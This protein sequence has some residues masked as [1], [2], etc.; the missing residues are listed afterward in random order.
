ME[1]RNKP[2]V[3]IIV[4]VYN[5]EKYLEKCINSILGQSYNNI[6]IILIDDGSTDESGFICDEYRRKHSNIKVKHKSNAGLGYARNTGLELIEGKYVTFIDSDDWVSSDLI[7]H[8]YE[9]TENNQVDFCKSGFQRVKHNGEIVSVTQY[10]EEIYEGERAAKELLPRLVGSSP[11]KHDSLEMCVCG[12]LYN[13]DIIKTNGIRF[14]SER[15]LIS[16][17]LVF[18]ID[19]LQHANG[20]CSIDAV[21]YFYC[22][23]NVS[24]SQGYRSDR[25]EASAYFYTEMRKKLEELGYDRD[26]ILRLDRMFFLYVQ[27]S[28]GQERKNVSGHDR[29]TSIGQINKICKNTVVKRTIAEYPIEQLGIRQRLFLKMIKCRMSGV[30]YSLANNGLI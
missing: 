3:S 5:V 2:L 29:K 18:N 27:M 30:L 17:D 28:I 26:V 22:V 20:A 1:C 4:P 19:Y 8:M 10:K 6:E 14:P 11:E 24:L 13:A 16:E 23:N 25:I 12:V 21:D 9:A 15:E 7:S